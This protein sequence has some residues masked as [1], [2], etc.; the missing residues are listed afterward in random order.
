MAGKPWESI[1]LDSCTIGG[2]SVKML[3]GQNFSISSHRYL[4]EYSEWKI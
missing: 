4:D 2:Q 1:N 3:R